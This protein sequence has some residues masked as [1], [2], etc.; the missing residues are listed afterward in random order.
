MGWDVVDMWGRLFGE[1]SL[2]RC[3][4]RYPLNMLVSSHFNVH[5]ELLV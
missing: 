4:P 1:F 3:S 5:E 2:P